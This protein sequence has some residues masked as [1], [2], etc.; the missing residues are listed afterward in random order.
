MN[1]K[2]A[3]MKFTFDDFNLAPCHSH[4]KSRKDPDIS[5]DL[6]YTKLEL[7]FFAAPMNTVVGKNMCELM[8]K[9]G[10]EAV[11]HR[12]MSI[13]EQCNLFKSII[14]MYKPFVAIGACGDLELRAETLYRKGARKFCIDI[15]NGHSDYCINAVKWL[16]KNLPEDI[17][18]MAGNVCTYEGVFNLVE[19][20]TDLIRVGIGSGGA[21][22]TRLVT[23]HGVPQLSALED[24]L[25]IKNYN[26]KAYIIADGGLRNS[27]DVIKC[28]ALG[29]DAVMIGSMLAS[30]SHTPGEPEI[31]PTT[32]TLYKHFAGMASEKGREGWFNRNDTS[33]VPEGVS[34]KIS[35][36]GDTEK[37]INN[38]SNGLRVGMSYNDAKTLKELKDN[39]Q[40]IR[41]TSNGKREGNPNSRMNK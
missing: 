7:P 17:V 41:I 25:K 15:A 10:G 16:K 8:G 39:A 23:G 24:C 32:G 2:D 37:I 27:G 26:K 20:G 29:T 36:K 35:Y 22:S 14:G 4:V 11:L 31:D 9:L 3:P 6:G 28:F 1:L 40:W 12:Y 19:A 34:F 38:L 30:S 33:F 21:C 18:I 13:K 5:S